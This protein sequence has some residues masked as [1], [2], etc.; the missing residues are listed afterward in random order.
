MELPVV[1]TSDE[2]LPPLYARWV[3]ELLRGSIPQET[4]ATC[5]D[6]AMCD[7]NSA[8]ANPTGFFFEPSIKCCTF[9][10]TL[11]NFIIGRILA[12][13]D[14]AGEAGRRSVEERLEEG[15]EVTPLGAGHDPT[16]RV[17]YA[18]MANAGAFGR[19]R[20]IR[21]P[22]FVEE[23]GA[24]GIWRHREAVCSTWFCKH[25]RGTVGSDFWRRLNALLGHVESELVQWCVVELDLGSPA[26]RRLFAGAPFGEKSDPIRDGLL[27]GRPDPQIRRELWGRWAGREREFYLRCA[28]LVDELSWDDAVALAGSR[29]RVLARLANES[30]ERL[31]SQAIPARAQTASF[32]LLRSDP[33]YSRVVTHNACDPIEIPRAVLEV[34]HYFDGRP[35]HQAIQDI[36]QER[37]LQLDESLIRKLADFR[38]LVESS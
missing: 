13:D 24:C 7:T 11:H 28:E 12:D 1:R 8:A 20:H 2:V 10:P 23:T 37:G 21:C 3:G 25:I 6:C 26:F 38:I 31:V 18:Q 32:E 22:H 17:L 34:L 33:D 14:P 29:G 4:E 16:Y 35:T 5:D 9:V 30:Y 15:V 27:D 36:A 19:S